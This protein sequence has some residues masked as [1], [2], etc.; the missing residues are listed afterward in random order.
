MP[1]ERTKITR[2]SRLTLPTYVVI[3]LGFGMALM[4]E[5][6]ADLLAVP[7]YRTLHHILP[8][9]AWALLFLGVGAVQAAALVVHK[10][11][12]YILTLG[13][14]MLLGGCLTVSLLSGAILDTNPWTAPWF[15]LFYTIGCLATLVSLEA[16]EQ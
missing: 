14:G 13:L 1:L 2:A 4:L 16:R 6:L 3:N 11:E 8:M 15:P 12:P 5:P 7:A 9:H 10:R